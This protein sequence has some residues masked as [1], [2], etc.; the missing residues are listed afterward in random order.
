MEN[1]NHK[2]TELNNIKE[3]WDQN[4]RNAPNG[5]PNPA[6]TSTNDVSL[7]DL[8]RIVKKEAKEYDN[9]NKVDRILSGDR[10]TLNDEPNTGASE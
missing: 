8:D 9:D 10:A 4:E 5:D 1:N 3:T 2:G 7:N 6:D